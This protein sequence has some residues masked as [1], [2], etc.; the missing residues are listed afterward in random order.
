[1]SQLRFANLPPAGDQPAMVYGRFAMAD[2]RPRYTLTIP[3]RFIADPGIRRLIEKERAGIGYNYATRCLLD[4]HLEDHD[5][6]IDVGAHWGLMA[7]QAATGRRVRTIAIE[8][9]AGNFW[10]LK[11]WIA[12]NRLENRID[13]LYAAVADSPGR[14]RL[15]TDG[16]GRRRPVIDPG[17][18][19]PLVSLDGLMARNREAEYR[20]IIVRI[21]ITGG[22]AGILKGMPRLLAGG[23]VAAVIW[24]PGGDN[25]CAGGRHRR[26]QLQDLFARHGFTV[27]QFADEDRAG[28]LLPFDGTTAGPGNVIAL[29]AGLAPLPFY[30][31]PVPPAPA[32]PPD[33]ALDAALAAWRMLSESRGMPLRQAMDQ[34]VRASLLDQAIPEIHDG[35]GTLFRHQGRLPAAVASFRRAVAIRPGDPVA[36]DHLAEA[37]RHQGDNP[38]ARPLHRR[39]MVLQPAALRPV[40]IKE[41]DDQ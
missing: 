10:H 3:R 29:A 23:C 17:G 16:D 24:T 22:E 15:L 38:A 39:A 1:M 2:G 34:L 8:P 11:R 30:G 37:L 26:R 31:Q 14:A 20:R 5:L 25:G 21:G 27:W 36:L 32:Q 35:L 13:T 6:F 28:A 4:T 7:L 40:F 9:G 18:N 41:R 33:D 19:I 12:E